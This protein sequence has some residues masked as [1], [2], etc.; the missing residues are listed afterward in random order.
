MKS[1]NN[2][3]RE[4]KRNPVQ[5]PRKHKEEQIDCARKETAQ[6]HNN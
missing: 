6:T 3:N 5:G 4:R 1:K 2:R